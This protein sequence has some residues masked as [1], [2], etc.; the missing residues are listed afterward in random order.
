MPFA[1]FNAVQ[2][3]SSPK[4]AR[5]FSRATLPFLSF[6]QSFSRASSSVQN[7]LWS[8]DS[9]PYSWERLSSV[10][11]FICPLA[12]RLAI[13][14][15]TSTNVFAWEVTTA[16]QCKK[17][18]GK[19]FQFS[20]TLIQTGESTINPPILLSYNIHPLSGH[21]LKADTWTWSTEC[22]LS[23]IIN[24]VLKKHSWLKNLFALFILLSIWDR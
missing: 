23:E 11:V 16:L 5:P 3:H 19:E 8:F 15:D 22:P 24:S 12:V 17:D 7:F 9:S 1:I 4:L 6:L 18:N 13:C 10:P 2:P 14:T 21:L 20:L